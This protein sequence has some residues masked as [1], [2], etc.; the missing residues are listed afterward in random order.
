K[1]MV[2]GIRIFTYFIFHA[3]RDVRALFFRM[4]RKTWKINPKLVKR[5]FTVITQYSHFH[6]FVEQGRMK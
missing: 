5:F 4:L 3:D 1:Q 2:F 6:S